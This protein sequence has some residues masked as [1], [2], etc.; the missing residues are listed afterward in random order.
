M[1]S[2]NTQEYAF[3]TTTVWKNNDGATA[4]KNIDRKAALRSTIFFN[5]LKVTLQLSGHH[6]MESYHVLK[7]SFF[8]PTFSKNSRKQ[9]N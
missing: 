5:F 9:V 2:A 8:L 4:G 3:G 1:I 6:H 7:S